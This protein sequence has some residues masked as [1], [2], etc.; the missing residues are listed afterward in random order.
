VRAASIR[1]ELAE[2]IAKIHPDRWPGALFVCRSCLDQERV[3][4]VLE[5]LRQEHGEL[6]ALEQE[7]AR[8]AA[9]HLTIARNIERTFEAQLTFGQRVADA[10]ARVGGSWRFIIGFAVFL[11][12]WITANSIRA[13]SAFDPFPFILLNLVLSCIAAVQAPVIMMSQNRLSARDR[14]QADEDYRINLKAELEVAALHEKIDHLL[15]NQWD[16]MVELQE[17][18]IDLLRQSS[19]KRGGRGPESGDDGAA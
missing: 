13:A 15:H 11:V 10:V 4:S 7:V 14:R 16:R 12:A 18:Q 3:S 6:S 8:K 17:L 9:G 19:S 5:R 2:W 1:P